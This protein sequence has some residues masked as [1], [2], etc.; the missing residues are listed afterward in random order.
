MTN[1][2]ITHSPT[3]VHTTPL[4]IWEHYAPHSGQ[5]EVHASTANQKVEEIARRWG[6]S[7]SLIAEFLK[8]FAQSLSLE[9]VQG[10]IPPFHAWI[11]CPSFPQARQTWNEL[12]TLIPSAFIDD[13]KHDERIIYLKG[14]SK[15][16]WGMLEL[17][18]ADN[19]DA[20]QTVGLDFL[21]VSE[22]QDVSNEAFE[23]LVPTLRSP[24]RMQRGLYEGIPS[25]WPDHWFWRLCD[26]AKRNVD[27]KYA[28]FH[29]TAYENPMLSKDD[30][31]E[32]ES[33]RDILPDRA[34]RRMYLAERSE[35]GA[36]FTNIDPCTVGDLIPGPVPGVRY[37]GGL[38]LGRKRDATVLHIGEALGRRIV[39]HLSLDSGEPWPLQ[40]AMITRI[41]KEWGVER[42]IVDATGM[43][44]DIFTQEL[45]AEGVPVEPYII[46]GGDNGSRIELLNTIA[47]SLERETIHFPPVGSLVRQLRAIQPIR[48]QGGGYKIEAPAGEHDDEVFA[49][50]LFLMAADPARDVG[51]SSRIT[52][53][54]YLPSQSEASSGVRNG[55]GARMQREAKSRRTQERW[56]RS[57]IEV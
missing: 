40:R 24:G 10:L 13:I 44:G 12:L 15:R 36:F 54:R 30:L 21:G 23:K 32:I 8:V 25:T 33:D 9:P 41:A 50:G 42:L 5:E 55:L 45:E 37:V 35:G 57:G 53:M 19:A 48:R 14:S 4:N 49:L 46:T 51:G 56:M 16:P 1:K 34:W 29:A 28:Y 47:V 20:L 7:R 39:F 43:G 3:P 26:V 11:V 52:R 38:D 2:Q 22:S 31:K 6:K 18:S 17:K 27:G